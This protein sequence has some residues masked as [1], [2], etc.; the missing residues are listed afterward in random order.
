MVTILCMFLPDIQGGLK[1]DVGKKNGKVLLTTSPF[2]LSPLQK[3]IHKWVVL[4]KTLSPWKIFPY[5]FNAL[6]NLNRWVC[7]YSLFSCLRIG[8]REHVLFYKRYKVRL[9]PILTPNAIPDT[10]SGQ[11]FVLAYLEKQASRENRW[12][13]SYTYIFKRG[14]FSLYSSTGLSESLKDPELSL[15]GQAP[16]FRVK[17]LK[18]IN[19]FPTVWEADHD[20]QI[21]G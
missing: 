4:V 20:S 7:T 13:K 10:F 15:G 1:R 19:S 2:L 8:Q 16:T 14:S 17:S 5:I 9:G 21:L 6:F 18:K 12:W 3:S 11:I